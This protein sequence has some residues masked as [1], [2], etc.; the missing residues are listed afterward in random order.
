MEESINRVRVVIAGDEY[1]I[2][3]N[4]SAEIITQ[5]TDYLNGKIEEAGKGIASKERYKQA[6]LAA[7]NITA[8]LFDVQKRLVENQDKLEKMVFKAKEFS[9]TLENTVG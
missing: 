6:I 8:E 9:E 2:K 1:Q 4:A 3:G 5:I 7:V